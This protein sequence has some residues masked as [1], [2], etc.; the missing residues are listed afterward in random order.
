MKSLFDLIHAINSGDLSVLEISKEEKAGLFK[1][2][3]LDVFKAFR[4]ESSPYLSDYYLDKKAIESVFSNSFTAGSH[5]ELVLIRLTLIDSMYST[6]MRMRSYGLG[7]LAETITIMGS[8]NEL[9]SKFMSF[10]HNKDKSVFSYRKSSMSLYCDGANQGFSNLFDEGFGIEKNVKS[11]KKAWSLISKYASFLTRGD[12]PI[13][14]SVVKEMIPKVWSLCGAK[15][16]PPKASI[17]DSSMESYFDAID[18]LKSNMGVRSYNELDYI[19]WHVGKILNDSFALILT[20]EDYLSVPHGYSIRS[21]NYNTLPFLAH[22][23]LLLALF[24]LAH[25]IAICTK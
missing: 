18:I 14:D 16:T 11:N 13:Y 6:Q 23:K 2:S 3:L 21:I 12:F 15:A 24:D 7:E 20:M 4:E 9:R 5:L 19:L 1:E 10:L 22:N 25:L 17:L 8:D